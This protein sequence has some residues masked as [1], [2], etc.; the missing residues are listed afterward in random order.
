MRP[1]TDQQLAVI[2]ERLRKPEPKQDDEGSPAQRRKPKQRSRPGLTPAEEELSERLAGVSE[3]GDDQRPATK[4][5][6]TNHY[7]SRTIYEFGKSGDDHQPQDD[8]FGQR[9]D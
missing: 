6:T 2:D 1:L 7:D 9:E 4:Y 8:Y 3:S 5:Y